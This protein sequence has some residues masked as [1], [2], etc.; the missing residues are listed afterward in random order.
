M[1]HVNVGGI[2]SN[3]THCMDVSRLTTRW[4]NNWLHDCGSLTVV[5]WRNKVFLM[6]LLVS[7]LSRSLRCVTKLES[8]RTIGEATIV[9][10]ECPNVQLVYQL[11]AMVV[12]YLTS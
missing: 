3:K 6:A 8:A 4:T 1:D 11:C 5:I 12:W 9:I 2:R 7:L 10:H